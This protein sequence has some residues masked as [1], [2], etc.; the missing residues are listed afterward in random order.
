MKPADHDARSKPYLS[1][2]ATSRNDNHGGDLLKRMQVFVDGLRDQS[3][4]H[5]V[6]TEL[7]LV[8][9]NPPPDRDR[10]DVALDWEP[11]DRWFAPR[12]VTV[13]K[14]VH[15]A[16]PNAQGQPLFQFIAKNVG[17]RRAQGAWLLSTNVDIVLSDPLMAYLASGAMQQGFHFRADRV[18]VD[19][20]IMDEP[21]LEARLAFA[22]DHV[23]RVNYATH[24]DVRV[25]SPHQPDESADSGLRAAAALLQASVSGPEGEG[26]PDRLA[27]S[28][29]RLAV[30][31]GAR[32]ARAAASAGDALQKLA[33]RGRRT[34]TFG[35]WVD[36]QISHG[37]RLPP[38]HYNACGD[39]ML[40]HRDDWALIDGHPELPY[41]SFHLDSLTLVAAFAAG[42]NEARLPPERCCF[43]VEHGYWWDWSDRQSSNAMESKMQERELPVLT[44]ASF[45]RLAAQMLQRSARGQPRLLANADWGLPHEDL[46]AQVPPGAQGPAGAEL[47]G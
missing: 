24:T 10:L 15:D 42:I 40:M 12:I 1:V 3:R 2:V 46:R 44:W 22:E 18:D 8:E 20:A 16:L 25:A 39:F 5:Q 26:V 28:A 36:E 31:V 29:A 41:Y 32:A 17:L 33:Q 9:W 14:D 19:P 37:V 47:R 23:L 11:E 7:V 21:D 30:V 4:R 43:H 13:E 6:P 45:A 35:E 34:E 38:L 27:P